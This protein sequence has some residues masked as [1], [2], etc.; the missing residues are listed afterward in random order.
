MRPASSAAYPTTMR[1]WS[2]R[3][4]SRGIVFAA[5]SGLIVVALMIILSFTMLSSVGLL[6][7]ALAALIA[8]P[9]LAIVAI[10]LAR[11]FLRYFLAP[12]PT[13]ALS[14]P[15]EEA[16]VLV[17]PVIVRSDR[18]I[19]AIRSNVDANLMFAARKPMVILLDLPDATAAVVP[20]DH[21]LLDS[22]HK[23]MG[24][25]ISVGRVAI[26]VRR[27][28]LDPVDRVW[29][30][31]E[32]K[33]GKI[34]E[35]CRL[36]L[37]DRDTSF[38]DSLPDALIGAVAFVTIDIDTRLMPDTIASLV[39]AV[40]PEAAIVTPM[41]EDRCRPDATWFEG[42]VALSS[43]R[44]AYDPNY[45]FNQSRL[46]YDLYYGKGLI[47]ARR[48]LARTKGKIAERTILS[49]DHLESMIAGAVLSPQAV[50]RED[51]PR[52]RES[53][54]RRQFRW[55]RGD[56]QIVPWIVRSRLPVVSR[57]HLLE[58]VLG[59]LAAPCSVILAMMA[60]TMLPAPASFAYALACLVMAR[61]SLLI[62][63]V[64]MPIIMLGSSISRSGRWAKTGSIFLSE[65]A[66]WML[67]LIYAPGNLVLVVRAAVLV[68]WR[69]GWSGQKL[70]EWEGGLPADYRVSRNGWVMG[71]QI[72]V[73]TISFGVAVL[74][75][76]PAQFIAV[77]VSLWL[78]VPLLLSLP[79]LREPHARALIHTPSIHSQ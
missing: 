75:D 72:L 34:E 32:R 38:E 45:N 36:L 13:Q 14:E 30:G 46:G 73:G 79:L 59:H 47:V 76:H 26:L 31:W 42:L 55:I 2:T 1:S 6:F 4:H 63:P 43:R 3:S 68:T 23:L 18:D 7:G 69:L 78:L 8:S 71:I 50:V 70:L 5:I 19:E 61:P 56:F 77:S 60:L 35:F 52:S 57:L 40:D 20:D 62:F 12:L 28:L 21:R 29:R 39:A 9:V 58:I 27:R 41:L 11:L 51:I 49:H 44:H 10:S 16:P 54:A 25:D 48:F 24:D 22:L 67:S 53:W 74:V 37:A 65:I 17:V 64:T 66:A 33:R 15:V